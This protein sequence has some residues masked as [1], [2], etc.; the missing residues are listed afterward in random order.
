[1]F[2]RFVRVIPA[3]FVSAVLAGC[4]EAREPVIQVQ[5]NAIAKS[6]FEG[7]WYFQRTVIDTPYETEFTF[8]GDQ[9]ELERVRWR[10][11]ENLLLALRS[12]QR[13]EGLSLIHI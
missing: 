11:E 9:G 2:L 10:V 5:A 4:P 12:Y 7:E 8:I 1:M 6:Q 13:V 3:L